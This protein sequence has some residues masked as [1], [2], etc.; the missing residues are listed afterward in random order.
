[1]GPDG[2]NRTRSYQDGESGAESDAEFTRLKN[3][4]DDSL[5]LGKGK[6]RRRKVG[7]RKT[8][9]ERPRE[10]IPVTRIRI[11]PHLPQP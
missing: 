8:K 3:D 10:S 2:F 11:T 6:K 1:M 5:I 4:E 9:K 7:K